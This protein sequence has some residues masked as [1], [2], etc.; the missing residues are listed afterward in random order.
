MTA[1][2]TAGV[3]TATMT[4][5]IT[6]HPEMASATWMVIVDTGALLSTGVPLLTMAMPTAYSRPAYLL[7]A[8]H[9]Q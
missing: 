9:V 6:M 2:V 1:P 5:T 4:T 7:Y 8:G 3:P